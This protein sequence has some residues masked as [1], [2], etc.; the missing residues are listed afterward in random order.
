MG[1]AILVSQNSNAQKCNQTLVL[2]KCFTNY[3]HILMIKSI[4]SCDFS[5]LARFSCV[6]FTFL[7]VFLMI[8]LGRG[9]KGRLSGR[10]QLGSELTY[11]FTRTHQ[12]GFF[13]GNR[14]RC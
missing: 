9:V 5:K 7:K 6:L 13:Q 10:N 2:I 3:D 8:G 11:I 1:I 4:S 12:V 14:I